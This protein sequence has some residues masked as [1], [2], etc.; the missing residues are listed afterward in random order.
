MSQKSLVQKISEYDWDDLLNFWKSIEA[1]NT[2]SWQPGEAFEYLILRAFQLEGATVRWPYIVMLE[3]E[4]IEQ[5]DGAVYSDGLCCLIECKNSTKPVNTGPIAKLRNQ[6]LRRPSATIGLFFSRSGFTSPAMSVAR[7]MAPQTMLL[8]TG[9]EVAYALENK[10]MR[11][12]LVA[13]YRH[14][15]EEGFPNYDVIDKDLL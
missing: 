13:K 7:F 4:E 10:L 11:R 8:W 3:G 14:C 12:A 1:G 6:L 15:I 9:Y 2:P 5:I